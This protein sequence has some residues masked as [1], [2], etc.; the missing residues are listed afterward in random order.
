MWVRILDDKIYL[1]LNKKDL[2]MYNID[3]NKMA[4]DE[5]L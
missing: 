5:E 2:L 3:I 4:T 1:Y